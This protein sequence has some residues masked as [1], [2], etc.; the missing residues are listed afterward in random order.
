MAFPSTSGVF[1]PT[2]VNSLN[3]VASL[4]LT[5]TTNVALYTNSITGAN[6][7]TDTAY[8]TGAW[9]FDEVSGDGYTAGGTALVSP[10][11]AHTA[12]GIVMWDADNPVWPASTI[13]ARGALYYV[14]ADSRAIFAQTFGADIQTLVGTFTIQYAGTGIFNIDCV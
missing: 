9:G 11:W 7:I 3:G 4:N 14:A 6:L 5:G 2:F 10:T 1:V 8:G 12:D 13:T